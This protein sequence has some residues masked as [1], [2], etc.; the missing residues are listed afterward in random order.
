[1]PSLDTEG[2]HHSEYDPSL[3]DLVLAEAA[4][5]LRHL[6]FSAQHTVLIGGVVPSLLVL[7]P[8]TNRPHLGTTDL[9]LCLSVAIV[10][11]DTTEYERIETALRNAGYQPTD[12]SF[13]WRQ[14]D[15]FKLSVEF[16]CPA[17]EGR[18]PGKL[19]R[20]RAADNPIAK[21]NFGPKLT[22]LALDAGRVIGDD[23]VVVPREVA[24]PGDAGRTT[25]EFRVT[26]VL[27]FL[28]AK[29]GALVGRDKPKDAYDIV[30]LIEN[31]EDGPAGA[32]AAIARSSA[33]G[34]PEVGAALER[35][36]GEFSETDG[37]GPS[38]YVRF[39]AD[40]SM[41]ADDRQRLARQA[42]G[43]LGALRHGLGR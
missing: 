34:R 32:A 5:L 18:P 25:F 3:V 17:G 28:V 26:G 29:I 39:M 38:S 41:T 15:R 23:V 16:F 22:A 42:V 7:D 30:W 43:A 9:D 19:F 2:R 13:R 11:G 1:M 10:E 31:F 12:A 40:A 6:G 8:V 20:P 37:L 27:G 4:H 24:L 21:Q 14:T 35:L 36:F 33:F